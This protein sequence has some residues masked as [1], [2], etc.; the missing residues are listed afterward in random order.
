MLK[1]I[2]QKKLSDFAVALIPVD[3]EEALS[4][5]DW[6]CYVINLKKETVQNVLITSRGYGTIAEEDRRSATLRYFYPEITGQTAV[7]LEVIQSDLTELTNEYW[8]SF[9]YQGHMYDRKFVFV[10][11]SLRSEHLTLIPVVEERGVM[12]L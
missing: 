3:T 2:E 6:N 8:V 9:N 10:P 11:D 5:V 4:Q 12:I 7:K 1:D